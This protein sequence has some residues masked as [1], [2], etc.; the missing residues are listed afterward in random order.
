MSLCK[1]LDYY[2]HHVLKH[3]NLTL[4]QIAGFIM[5]VLLV[6]ALVFFLV[7]L[8]V[9]LFNAGA[10][11]D[12]ALHGGFVGTFGV[13]GKRLSDQGIGF[14]DTMQ[15]LE[16]KLEAMLGSALVLVLGLSKEMEDVF[17]SLLKEVETVI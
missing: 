10:S 8:V 15:N 7:T 5:I 2:P 11:L 6:I 12:S 13:I 4:R 16:V 3:L 9:G 14:E 17:L 1:W